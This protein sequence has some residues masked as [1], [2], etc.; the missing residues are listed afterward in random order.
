MKWKIK[1]FKK[2]SVNNFYLI[3]GLPGMGNVGKISVDFIIDNLNAEKVMEIYSYSFPHCV[4]VNEENLVELPS[5]KIYQKKLKGVSFMFVAGDIQPLD[6]VSCY[7]FCNLLLDLFNKHKIKE[8]IT[9]G[10][11]GQHQIPKSPKLYCTGNDKK[12]IKKYSSEKVTNSIYGV[13]GPIIGVSGLLLGTA[14]QRNIP[15]VVILAETYSSPIYLGVKGAREIIKVLND[16]FNLKLKIGKINVEIE[17][18]EKGF[19]KKVAPIIN[20]KN[21]KKSKEDISYI[22]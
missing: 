10:G 4:F 2:I 21:I 9:L 14:A 20:I 3:E 17:E 12:I 8:I 13:V 6:E 1:N 5:I 11:I 18:I 7:E 15:A 16:K 19:K 22:G